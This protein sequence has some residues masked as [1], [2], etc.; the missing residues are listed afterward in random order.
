MARAEEATPR[1]AVVLVGLMASGKSTVGRLVASALD[2]PFVD[3]DEVIEQQTGR[4]VGKL[5]HEGGEAAYRPLERHAVIGALDQLPPVVL[6][7]PSGV[8]DDPD[9][10]DRLARPEV[11]V[12][13]LR[14]EVDT[15]AER[16][17]A[18]DQERPL[19]GD[20]PAAVLRQQAIRRNPRYEALA[21]VIVDL[22][23]RRAEELADRV[24]GVLRA[25]S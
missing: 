6:A 20:D 5:W 16:I 10:I 2:R 24:L 1:G 9:L 17:E 23:G 22:D 3:I 21:S 25:T 14:G 4:S 15:L 19:V 8:I 12:A 11:F 7:A 18:D 13:F